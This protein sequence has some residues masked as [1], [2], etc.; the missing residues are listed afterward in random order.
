MDLAGE[1]GIRKILTY[2]GGFSN[3]LLA[4][5]C[6]SAATGIASKA[7]IRGSSADFNNPVLSLCRIYGM[8]L[9]SLDKESYR[10]ES[11]QDARIENE[12]LIIPEGG[13]GNEAL[14]GVMQGFS[15][16]PLVPDHVMMAVG[17]GTTLAGWAKAIAN[18]NLHTKVHGI[19]VIKGEG[20]IREKITHL[21]QTDTF[22]LHAEFHFGGYAKVEPE[23]TA[24]IRRFA[25]ATGILTDP[26]Y[27]GKMLF[28]LNEMIQS[29]YFKRG[30]RIVALHSGGLTG[31]MN[32]YMLQKF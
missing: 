7:F 24:F 15:E 30:E 16:L 18:R 29:G 12:T 20:N 8:E 27:T 17:T 31:M 28:A 6:A 13:A 14:V 5:A 10:R 23:L 2:G 9:I 26:V 4:T 11:N 32:P 3:H 21:A 22:H 25:S 1:H 19:L